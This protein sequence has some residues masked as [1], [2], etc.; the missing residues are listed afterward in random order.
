M[1]VITTE[2]KREDLETCDGYQPLPQR[3]FSLKCSSSHALKYKQALM[4]TQIRVIHLGTKE[5]K[6]DCITEKQY[7][8]VD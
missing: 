5:S 7:V 3:I 4:V 8:M 1:Y 2:G 6:K